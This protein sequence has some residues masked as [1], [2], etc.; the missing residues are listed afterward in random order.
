M[1]VVFYLFVSGGRSL[2]Y[3]LSYCEVTYFLSFILNW[4]MVMGAPRA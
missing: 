2:L 3:E 1:V 4:A